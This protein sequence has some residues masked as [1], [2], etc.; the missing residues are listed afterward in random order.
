MKLFGYDVI[1]V[2]LL[3]AFFTTVGAAVVVRFR[4]D[5][6]IRRDRSL[7]SPLH[8]LDA[9]QT[10]EFYI[11]LALVLIGSGLFWSI[12]SYTGR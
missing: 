1:G 2:A 7:F 4:A 6:K 3:A 9:L 11:F 10:N 8:V 5:K 12:K